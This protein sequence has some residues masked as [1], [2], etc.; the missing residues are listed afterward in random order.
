MLT[1]KTEVRPSTIHGLGLFAAQPIPRGMKIWEPNELVDL[2]I[3]PLELAKIPEPALKVVKRLSYYSKSEGKY[4]LSAD[5]AQYMNHS[6]TP[7]TGVENG[8]NVALR[9]IKEGEELTEDYYQYD[10]EAQEKLEI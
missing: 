9:D 5:G 10:L 3:T 6:A 8:E 7:N 1:V 4:I 2:Y